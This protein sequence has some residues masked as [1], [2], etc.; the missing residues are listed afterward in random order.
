[1]PLSSL[2][3][4]ITRERDAEIVASIG[5]LKR[6]NDGAA[7]DFR[8]DV[9]A[10]S[11]AFEKWLKDVAALPP[12]DQVKAVAAKLKAR[13]PGFDGQMTHRV[14]GAAVSELDFVTDDVTDIAPVRAL[15]GLQTLRCRGSGRG[16]GQLADLSPLKGMPLTVLNITGTRVSDLSPLRDMKL[17]TLHCGDTKVADL[18]PVKGMPLKELWGDFRPERDAEILRSIKTLEKINDKPVAEFLKGV[19]AGKP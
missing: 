16:K 15:T 2:S 17:T 10:R 19:D 6:L 14:E 11:A 13:N 9:A 8:K 18:A 1:M 4:D 5:T 12:D 7:A 3:C